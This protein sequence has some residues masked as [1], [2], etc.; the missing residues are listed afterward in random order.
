MSHLQQPSVLMSG[1]LLVDE[2]AEDEK[3]DGYLKNFFSSSNSVIF[4]DHHIK[5]NQSS[6][7]TKSTNNHIERDKIW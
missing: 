3:Y 5:S 7:E 4:D 2:E 1:G 6:Y